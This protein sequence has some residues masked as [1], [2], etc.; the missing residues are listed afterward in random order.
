MTQMARLRSVSLSCVLFGCGVFGVQGALHAEVAVVTVDSGERVVGE[1]LPES[2]PEMLAIQSSLFGKLTIARAR[3]VKIERQLAVPVPQAEPVRELAAGGPDG[4]TTSLAIA[5]LE[6][7]LE[8]KDSAEPTV[9]KVDVAEASAAASV[10][11]AGGAVAESAPAVAVTPQ[12]MTREE[13]ED[14]EQERIEKRLYNS[15][16]GFSAPESWKGSVKFGLNLSSGDSEWIETN[17]SGKLDIREQ[18]SPHLNRFD[19]YYVYRENERADGSR[20]KSQD[21]YGASH[22]YRYSLDSHWFVQNTLAWRVDQKKGIDRDLSNMVGLGYGFKP[23][24][25]VKYDIGGNFGI[26]QYQ[27]ADQSTTR[28]GINPLVGVFH[29]LKWNPLKRTTLSHNFRYYINPRNTFQYSF[30]TQ[31]ALRV[32]M[33]DLLGVEFSYNKN[34]DN[35]TGRGANKNDVRWLNALIVYF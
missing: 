11:P 14:A 31:T 18:N 33:T 5:D 16:L 3:V 9:T 22:V 17:L 24:P 26:G 8:N 7:D 13:L 27:T 28:E 10:A 1:V 23:H 2:T 25:T 4:A 20:Y 29:D 32:R 6:A 35:D 34:Y 30:L 12:P 19:G 21:R 15:F